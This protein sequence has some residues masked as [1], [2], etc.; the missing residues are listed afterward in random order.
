MLSNVYILFQEAAIRPRVRGMGLRKQRTKA[1][2]KN[3]YRKKPW[4]GKQTHNADQK[5]TDL[6][7]NKF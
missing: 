2:S 3:I 4:I 7:A 5:Q 1:V 6:K